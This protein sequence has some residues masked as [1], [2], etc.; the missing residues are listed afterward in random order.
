MKDP[1]EYSLK[2]QLEAAKIGFDWPE[3]TPVVEKL[4]EELLEI[5]EAIAS[6]ERKKIKEE[7]GDFIFQWINLCR[8]LNLSP[9]VT[10]EKATQKF[11]KRLSIVKKAAEKE[12]I[13]LKDLSI[14]E[15]GALWNL[16]KK[17]S[18]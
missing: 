14:N 18:D 13:S 3:I 5:H 17:L 10:L 12:K 11:E 16:A 1:L 8:H 2:V 4:S 7:M 15:L 6:G 9:T